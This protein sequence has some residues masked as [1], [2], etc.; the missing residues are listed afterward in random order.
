MRHKAG[1]PGTEPQKPVAQH[2][3]HYIG[4]PAAPSG[5][6]RTSA[7][8][9]CWRDCLGSAAR[10]GSPA[11]P[12]LF[13]FLQVLPAFPPAFPPTLATSCPPVLSASCPAFR[14]SACALTGLVPLDALIALRPF[15]LDRSQLRAAG[16]SRIRC[17]TRAAREAREREREGR[18]D[19]DQRIAEFEK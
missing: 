5:S 9:I 15:P 4:K 10:H 6:S 1:Y 3:D 11:L 2:G 12:I 16:S 8:R 17:K 7:P 18:G 14:L 13:Y 19:R